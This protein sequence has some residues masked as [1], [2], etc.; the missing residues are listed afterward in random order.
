L[1]RKYPYWGW[2]EGAVK[3]NGLRCANNDNTGCN[4]GYVNGQL[5]DTNPD[6]PPAPPA[7]KP[8]PSQNNPHGIPEE[9]MR[10]L[11]LDVEQTTAA[12]NL[13]NGPEQSQSRW[14][15]RRN[16][17]SVYGYCE[18]IGDERGVTVGLTGF[19]TAFNTAQNIIEKAGGPKFAPGR[20][21]TNYYPDER[22]LCKWVKDNENNPKFQ[23]AQWDI[24]LSDYIKP[25]MSDLRKYVPEHI[26][27]E[28][29]VIAAALDATINQGPSL[30]GNCSGDFMKNAQGNDRANWLNSFLNLRNAKFTS[31][32][33]SQMREGRLGAFRKLAVNDKWDLRNVDP[34]RFNYCSGFPCVHC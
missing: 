8:S 16:K 12:L 29:L 26:R 2:D 7:P 31:G 21:D 17:E 20:K 5:V 4:T 23:K 14:W 1:E 18:N 15:E 25:M 6:R 9:V 27:K 11:G 13:I 30:C 19:V 22:A 24:Y 32:N 3:H 28:P 34:C 10:T 33:T